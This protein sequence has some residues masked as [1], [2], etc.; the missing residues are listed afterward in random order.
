MTNRPLPKWWHDKFGNLRLLMAFPVEGYV[1]ARR[2][3]RP[4]I[5]IRVT[6]LRQKFTEG[7]K[8]ETD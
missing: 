4:V 1:M 2:P 6:D 7:K 5:A 3:E 8:D